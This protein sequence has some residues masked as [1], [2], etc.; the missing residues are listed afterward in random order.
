MVKKEQIKELFLFAILILLI[1]SCNSVSVETIRTPTSTAAYPVLT[2]RPSATLAMTASP[3]MPIT[4]VTIT[5]TAKPTLS[6]K[7]KENIIVQLFSVDY[8]CNLPCFAKIDPGKTKW[9]E[10]EE[11]FNN[12]SDEPVSNPSTGIYVAGLKYTNKTVFIDFYVDKGINEFLMV[13]R[14]KFPITRLLTLYGQ[15]D[16]IFFYVLDVLPVDQTIPYTIYLFYKKGFV[17]QY[18]GAS[19]RGTTLK[20]CLNNELDINRETAFIWLWDGRLNETFENVINNYESKFYPSHATLEYFKLGDLSKL[21]LHSFFETYRNET[22]TKC[23]EL[24]NPYISR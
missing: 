16:E 3:T 11:Y 8:L 23:L 18:T 1:Q 17:V 4:A 7:E 19:E 15:P 24:R 14:Y 9:S 5:P 10:I 21:D 6:Q 2:R 12:L 13:P 20:V 22:S